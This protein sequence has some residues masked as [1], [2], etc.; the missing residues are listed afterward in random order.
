MLKALG[1]IG[2]AALGVV[3]LPVDAAADVVNE[4]RSIGD[5][6]NPHP[7]HMKRKAKSIMRNL[8]DA[9]E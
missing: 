5:P 7:S 9:S 3:T 1:N 2:K 4:L 8:H 6:Y